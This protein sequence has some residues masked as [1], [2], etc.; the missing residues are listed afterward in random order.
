MTAD[1]HPPS[2]LGSNKAEPAPEDRSFLRHI[3][4]LTNELGAPEGALMSLLTDN[5]WSMI[6]KSHALIE[7]AMTLLL[8]SALTE[9]SLSPAF[10][11]LPLSEDITGTLAFA[12]ALGL[13][14]PSERRFI[15]RL[16]ELRNML[17][18]DPRHLAFTLKQYVSGMDKNKLTAFQDAVVFAV[19]PERREEERAALVTKPRRV[20]EVTVLFFLS[21]LLERIQHVRIAA[22]LTPTERRRVFEAL[23]TEGL[24]VAVINRAVVIVAGDDRT[25]PL[26][27]FTPQHHRDCAIF[28]EGP[29]SSPST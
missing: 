25:T 24:I 15:K 21:E 17:A 3:S 19:A 29:V 4:Q 23:G 16:S 7:G 1:E 5:D 12:K 2:V 26:A 14:R 6:I 27:V 20:F 8:T 13:L 28:A 11:R 10:S 22:Y 18:H 9:T